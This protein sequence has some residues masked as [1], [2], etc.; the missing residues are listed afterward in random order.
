LNIDLL[1]GLEAYCDDPTYEA[2]KSVGKIRPEKLLS[3]FEVLGILDGMKERHCVA[4]IA[5]EEY[6]DIADLIPVMKSDN[7]VHPQ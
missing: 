3:A 2:R 7:L 6:Y 4:I 1:L 5:V